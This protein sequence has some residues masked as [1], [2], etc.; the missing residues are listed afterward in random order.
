MLLSGFV[1]LF[2]GI[3]TMMMF[4]RE[5][6]NLSQAYGISHLELRL[7]RSRLGLV[8]KEKNTSSSGEWLLEFQSTGESSWI[9]KPLGL[10]PEELE[11]LA[12]MVQSKVLSTQLSQ[13]VFEVEHSTPNIQKS[14]LI[15]FGKTQQKFNSNFKVAGIGL[16]SS[17]K[18]LSPW[19]TPFLGIIVGTV[20][21]AFLAA[22]IVSGRLNRSYTLIERALENIGAGRLSDLKLPKSSDPSVGRLTKALEATVNTLALKEAKIAEV[23]SLANEDPMT[24][25]P[26]YRAFENYMKGLVLGASSSGAVP[27]LAIID[28]DHFK[29]VND[30]YGHQVGDFV[31]KE[32]TKIV[33]STISSGLDSVKKTKDF[34]ARYGG[35]EFVVIFTGVSPEES[36]V[37]AQRILQ[38]IKDAT[39]YIPADIAEKG[40]GFELKISASIG[41][42]PW[43]SQLAS[44]EE[45]IKEADQALYQAKH[46][47]RG[48]A[49][50]FKPSKQ[51]T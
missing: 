39:L 15:S 24:G 2:V 8:E 44:R 45:W 29:K 50:M 46:N 23:S 26:N 21:L 36:E 37:G 35:E 9:D 20:F 41:L 17:L 28:L 33:N 13:G 14:Y 19:A 43:R 22:I 18:R 49:E 10:S 1:A 4:S 31:L 25:V 40:K 5:W 30:T 3:A 32:T 51:G 42:S 12:S 47:G 38:A 16:D 11:G 6:L 27:V 34:F 48:R 7:E